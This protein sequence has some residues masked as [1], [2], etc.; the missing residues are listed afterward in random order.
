MLTR[1][2]YLAIEFVV[3]SMQVSEGARYRPDDCRLIDHEQ[4]GV[5]RR[6]APVVHFQ[7][8]RGDRVDQSLEQLIGGVRAAVRV[9]RR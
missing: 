7:G 5:G 1:L 2:H 4:N 9:W 6:R 3:N 8:L